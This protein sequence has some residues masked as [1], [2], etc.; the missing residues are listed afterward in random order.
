[1][2][3]LAIILLGIPV[4]LVAAA[5]IFIAANWAPEKSVA[6]LQARWAQP[7]STF[8]DI[9]GMKVHVRDEGPRDDPSPIVLM[10]GTG[11]SLH[12]WDG[13]ADALN[14]KR[15]VIRF[16]LAGYGLTGPSPDNVYGLDRDVAMV[17]ALLDKLGVDHCVLGGNS[18]GGA[19]TW[20]TAL[21]HPARVEK[22]I[23]V[24]A[25]GYPFHSTSIPIG[26]RLA[27]LPGIGWLMQNTLPRSLVE[28]G[29]RNVVGDPKSVTPEMI[30]RSIEL[31]QR[32]GNRRALIE[33][34]RQR[35]S[36]SMAHRIKE[37][38]QPTLVMWGGRDR[39][40]PPDDAERF[41]REI[42]GSTLVIF[43]DLGH[44]PEEEDSARSVAAVKKFL[45]IA[46]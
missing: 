15:R 5:G 21:A 7:P 17:I 28:Q 39:L 20:R 14:G 24:D 42:E 46:D 18:L 3:T 43:D 27:R 4:V 9:A 8:V 38:K 13:W 35:P 11:S 16:D 26:F 36:G 29:W 32:E 34:F 37:L 41:H 22:M 12:A 19:V 44:A 2:R 33:R 10:H 40:I 25:G 1:M 30:E 6:E 31:T 45:G 23:L